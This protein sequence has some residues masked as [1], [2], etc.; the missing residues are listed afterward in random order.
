MPD[1]SA[2]ENGKEIGEAEDREKIAQTRTSLGHLQLVDA[3]INHIAFK[4]DWH[5]HQSHEPHTDF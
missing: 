1:R 4:I 2:V 3:K 5:A